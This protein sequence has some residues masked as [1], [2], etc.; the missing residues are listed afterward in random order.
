[1]NTELIR[2]LIQEGVIHEN[3]EIDACYQ[4]VDIG[5]AQLAMVQGNF[6]IKA[7]K[8][9]QGGVFFDTV[10]TQDGSQRRIAAAA[11]VRIDGM[12]PERF[13]EN[14]GLTPEGKPIK[15]GKRRGRKPKAKAKAADA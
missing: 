9:I 14:Y 11:I 12:E 7:A 10:S 13:A 4:G 3:T 6:A 5:G 8:V 15:Q 1:V 2:K